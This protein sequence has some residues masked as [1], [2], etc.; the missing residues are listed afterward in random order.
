MIGVQVPYDVFDV[1]GT[2]IAIDAVNGSL[3]LYGMDDGLL[4]RSDETLESG[5]IQRHLSLSLTRS[6]LQKRLAR[7]G[8]RKQP[9]SANP[10][11][12]VLVPYWVGIFERDGAVHI[13]VLDAIRGS[14]EGGKMR[15]VIEESFT[16]RREDAKEKLENE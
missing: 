10:V 7:Q 16:R 2:L 15:D 11:A 4:S 12:T 1:I 14:L 8:K 6:C 9:V 13:E 3:D 5:A